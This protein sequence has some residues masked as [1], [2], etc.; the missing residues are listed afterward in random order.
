M[1]ARITHYKM[2]ADSIG[3]ATE[4]IHSLKSQIMALDGMHQF[5]N[6]MKSDGSGYVISLVK[7]EAT[8]NANADKV[9]AL[10]ANF[11]PFLEAMPTPEGY[12]VVVD[13]SA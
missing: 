2:K 13:W 10:W 1:F 5:I 4:M 11:G 8:S 9:K 7:D 6:V 12:D 3:A